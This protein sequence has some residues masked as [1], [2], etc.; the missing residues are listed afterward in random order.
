MLATARVLYAR[1]SYRD[2]PV[3]N[4]SVVCSTDQG[5][6][7]T[8]LDTGA[9]DPDT[10]F[11]DGVYSRYLQFLSPGH[12]SLSCSII[13]QHSHVVSAKEKTVLSPWTRSLCC[14]SVTIDA[15][16]QGPDPPS[17][18]LLDLGLQ[19]VTSSQQIQL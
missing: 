3:V 6:S 9:G 18:G 7:L 4:A 12:H 19:V 14:V 1:V 5:Y 8:L 10:V 17:A 16:V 11:G 2:Q 13:G 15:I